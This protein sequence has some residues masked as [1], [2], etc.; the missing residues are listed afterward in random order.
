MART[1]RAREM[2]PIVLRD[3]RVARAEDITPSMRRI[4]LVGEQLGAHVVHG[5]EFP[6][7]VSAGFDDSLRMIFPNPTTGQRPCPTRGADGK[8]EWTEE[9]KSHYRAY[10]VRSFNAEAGELVVDFARHGHGLAEDWSAHAQP[11]D[12]VYIAGPKGSSALP[13]HTDWLLLA[14]DETALPAMGRAVESLPSN[15]PA[16]AFIEVPTEADVQDLRHGDNVDLRWVIRERGGDFVAEVLQFFDATPDGPASA[17]RPHGVPFLSAAGEAE[18]LK[19]LRQLAKDK[20]IPPEHVQ[21]TGYW[22][23]QQAAD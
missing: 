5:V 18:R 15:H 20:R 13:T 6:A 21:I 11:G 1:S 14:G 3:L 9:A 2:N 8:L 19:P 16:I 10:T 12:P 22:R 7:L 23:A 17:K 4:T